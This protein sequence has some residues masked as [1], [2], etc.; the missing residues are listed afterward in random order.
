[1]SS[2]ISS[3]LGWLAVAVVGAIARGVVAL[4]RGEPI[5]AVWLVVAAAC[6]YLIAYRFYSLYIALATHQFTHALHKGGGGTSRCRQ[7]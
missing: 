3:K 4:S 1:M 5:N 7:R 2:S 6:V